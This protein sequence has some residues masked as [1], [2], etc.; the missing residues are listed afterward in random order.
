MYEYQTILQ[1]EEYT[2]YVTEEA[3]IK[4]YKELFGYTEVGKRTIK[5]GKVVEDEYYKDKN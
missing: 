1:K 2:V 4:L 5:D 3:D